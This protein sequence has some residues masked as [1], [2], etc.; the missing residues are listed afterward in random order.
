MVKNQPDL[1]ILADQAG[2]GNSR[3]SYHNFLVA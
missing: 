2:I 1:T 3:N